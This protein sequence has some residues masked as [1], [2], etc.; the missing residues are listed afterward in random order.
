MIQS[1]K[2]HHILG[3]EYQ[4]YFLLKSVN[5]IQLPMNVR[6]VLD[7]RVDLLSTNEKWLIRVCAVVG[8]NIP[9]NLLKMTFDLRD[10]ELNELLNTLTEKKF[11]SKTQE[12]PEIIFTFNHD[13]IIESV[14]SS[15]LKTQRKEMHL[16]ILEALEKNFFT[17]NLEEL[18][19]KANHAFRGEAWYK[20]VYYYSILQAN[21]QERTSCH[22][23]LEFGEKVFESYHHLTNPSKEESLIFIRS[24]YH[25]S[26]VLF[27]LGRNDEVIKFVPEVSEVVKSLND[28]MIEA[29]FYFSLVSQAYLGCGEYELAEESCYK[30]LKLIEKEAKKPDMSNQ[31]L[32]ILEKFFILHAHYCL[33][34]F[35]KTVSYANEMTDYITKEK[36]EIGGAPILAATLWAHI[37]A[38][39]QLGEFCHAKNME[40]FTLE[41]LEKQTPSLNMYHEQCALARKYC[42]QG[43]FVNGLKFVDLS[44][45]TST[46]MNI[47]MLNPEL[48]AM[49]GYILSFKNKPDE[50]KKYLDMSYELDTKRKFFFFASNGIDF[51]CKGYLN[52]NM[53]EQAKIILDKLFELGEKRNQKALEVYAWRLKAEIEMIQNNPS[54]VQSFIKTIN[55]AEERGMLPEIG[56]SYRGLFQY[57]KKIGDLEKA[58]EFYKKAEDM[59][60]NMG[61]LFKPELL[62]VSDVKSHT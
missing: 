32:I 50:A 13:L 26:H 36:D 49:K 5:E 7:S 30:G 60:K 37:G 46:R 27:W 12:Y 10:D 9:V 25:M 28:P 44:L 48:L 43:D 54:V 55:F 58:N 47:N 2:D 59:Y 23:S 41:I 1:L 14:Y 16:S 6:T 20:A 40:E 15:I 17:D 62:M 8:K 51:L 39:A 18:T 52:L 45:E 11:I 35:K 57:Y 24:S 31:L 38:L 61:M 33:G 21:A 3:G 22:E 29:E 34:N 4:N 56:H 19:L 53:I 42:Y